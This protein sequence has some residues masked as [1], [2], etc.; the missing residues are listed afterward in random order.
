MNL[1]RRTTHLYEH[2]PLNS[3]E[4]EGFKT[5]LLEKRRVALTSMDGQL[6]EPSQGAAPDQLDQA[7]TE[8]QQ[9]MNARFMDRYR[10]MLAKLDKALTRIAMEEYDECES[11]SDIIDPKRLAARPETSMCIMCKEEQERLE[12]GYLSPRLRSQSPD[13]FSF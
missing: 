12:A 9:T 3:E 5:I 13:I 1:R 8:H 7:V 6:P 10:G 2:E 11:C 4:L